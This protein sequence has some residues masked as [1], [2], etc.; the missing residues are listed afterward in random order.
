[1]DRRDWFGCV[2]RSGSGALALST[3]HAN[4]APPAADL[5][6]T[7]AR[8][9]ARD[10]RP[11]PRL[12]VDVAAEAW[13]GAFVTVRVDASE[14]PGV[15]ELHLLRDDHVP[16]SIARLALTNTRSARWSLPVRLERPCRL[17]AFARIDSG[18][19]RAIGVVRTVGSPGCG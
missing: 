13:S 2:A 15:R 16:A 11:D 19:V 18:W 17:H 8:L 7:L 10:A 9:G 3:A 12:V 5:D 1:M 4:D 14:L 6:A